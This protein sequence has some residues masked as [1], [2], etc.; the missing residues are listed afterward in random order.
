VPQPPLAYQVAV[1][2]YE[3]G[4][5][6]EA[7]EQFE[8]FLKSHEGDV[9]SQKSQYYL[10]LSH[11]ALNEYAKGC[12]MLSDLNQGVPS[13][14]E[15][16]RIEVLYQLSL[17]YEEQRKYEMAISTLLDLQRRS[18]GLRLAVREIEIP[19][20]LG[21]LYSQLDQWDQ[22]QRHYRQANLRLLSQIDGSAKE[23][24]WIA[25]V[26]YSM[27]TMSTRKIESGPELDRFLFRMRYSQD[28]LIKSYL[29]NSHPWSQLALSSLEQAYL[30]TREYLQEHGSQTSPQESWQIKRTMALKFYD[31]LE[32]ARI[33]NFKSLESM[34]LSGPKDQLDALIVKTQF[35]LNRTLAGTAPGEG[36]T[37]AAKRLE[38]I[39]RSGTTLGPNN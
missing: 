1:K 4:L 35:E 19:S 34:A 13:E 30:K 31:L 24:S 32:E 6:E 36:L 29:L 28:F 17:C 15:L 16:Q 8:K 10:A 38:S 25:R 21:S 23:S 26:L 2:S 20:R 14:G 5:F 22:A 3:Q 18:R 33:K 9:Y 39:K 37:P 12:P 11:L 7:K 27:G